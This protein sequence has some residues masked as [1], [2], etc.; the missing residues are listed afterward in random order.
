MA[1]DPIILV[2]DVTGGRNGY[3]PPLN[4]PE[5]QCQ[6]ALNVD[7]WEGSLGNK[8]G[9]ATVLAVTFSSGGP[10]SGSGIGS[11][12]RHVPA[13]DETAAELWA[14]DLGST[15]RFARLA[16]SVQWV[17]ATVVDALSS[18]SDA[19]NVF[20]ASILGYLVFA[21]KSGVN[22]MHVWDPAISKIRRMGFTTAAPP[23]LGAMGAGGL[24]FTRFYRIRWVDISGADTRR[25]SEPS[26][27]V[28][29][30]I[31]AKLGITVTRP[32]LPG[33]DETHWEVEYADAAAGPWY[34][35]A[36]VAKATTTYDDTA[37]TIDTT[38][39]TA[40][41]GINIA[42]VS[43]RFVL[44][45]DARLIF[46][47]GYS[48]FTNRVWFTPVVGDNDVGDL[49]RV[50]VGNYRDVDASITGLAG[51]LQGSFFVFSFRKIW[52]FVPTLSPDA[53][54][55]SYS[56]STGIGCI[57]QQTVVY[58]ED[59]NGNPA[60]YFLSHRGPY[61]IGANGVQYIGR[62]IEDIWADNIN[63]AASNG[64]AHGVSHS[65]KHQIWWWIATG[66]STT[67]DTKVV[68][69]TQ[70]GRV[71]MDGKTVRKGWVKHDGASATGYASVAFSNTVGATMSR[72]LKPYLAQ[73]GPRRIWKCDST[74][75]DDDG[76][77]FRAYIDT[78][79]Y[80]PA[81]IG[82]NFLMNEPHLV[83][84]AATDVVIAVTGKS[85]FGWR[86]DSTGSVDLTPEN[87]ETRVQKKVEGFQNNSIG[88]V[89][90]RIGDA[91]AVANQWTLDALIVPCVANESR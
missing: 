1:K 63:L 70:I 91:A 43:A 68:F 76:V 86:E 38:N 67:P 23:T 5:D 61:R 52:Q 7:F 79:E 53:P 56:R 90:L 13:N 80:A 85:N 50:P 17:D 75:L 21:Y 9:G 59:E 37:A 27:S 51:P 25:R 89:S 87:T 33:E 35:A 60:I 18:A 81:G 4:I 41:D 57:R 73:A 74:A 46:A 36:Q 34:R 16:A 45:M 8:R 65:D 82:R 58:G 39:L 32:A 40:V 22:L 24:T 47:S 83:A 31:S 44:A 49:E 6:E 71:T 69:D 29:L 19:L 42:P 30:A 14:I 62:D 78:K 12:I 15:S 2:H 84:K 72:D 20:G 48:A 77:T 54:Y 66:T 55:V 88:S 11:L 28:S 64:V 10:F 26:T 3:D